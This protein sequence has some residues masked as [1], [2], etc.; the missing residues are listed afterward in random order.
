MSK[1]FAGNDST[2][3]ANGFCGYQAISMSCYVLS[4]PTGRA[5]LI[6]SHSGRGKPLCLQAGLTLSHSLGPAPDLAYPCGKCWN[7]HGLLSG[8]CYELSKSFVLF[9]CMYTDHSSRTKFSWVVIPDVLFPKQFDLQTCLVCS[10]RHICM[11]GPCATHGWV[12][13]C[14]FSKLNTSLVTA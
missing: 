2:P 11:A 4:P 5:P 9:L 12:Q 3:Y 10:P 6:Y 1:E 8:P 7:V 14:T 13:R